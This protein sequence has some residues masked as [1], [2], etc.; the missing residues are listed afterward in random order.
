MALDLETDDHEYDDKSPCPKC[1]C[2]VLKVSYGTAYV[3]SGFDRQFSHSVQWV[4]CPACDY[5]D[6]GDEIEPDE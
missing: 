3:G 2:K 1:G 6:N 4:E 5:R